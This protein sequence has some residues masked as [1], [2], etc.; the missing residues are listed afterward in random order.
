MFDGSAGWDLVT[1]L[2][3]GRVLEAQG[4]LWY[5]EPMREFDLVSYAKLCEDLKI[6]V[7]AA[8][9]SDGCHWNAAT[10]IEMKALD[11]MRT[12]THYKGGL[13]GGVKVAHLAESFGMRAEVHGGGYGNAHL[14]AAIPNNSYYEQ[15]V[16]DAEQIQGLK[17]AA[18]L[19][20]VDGFLTV[21]DTPGLGFEP[22]IERL[23]KTAIAIV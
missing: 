20:I 13:T 6:P 22:D 1:S 21:P 18:H 12:S 7:L 11:M 19:P 8:E 10:W 9:T 3:F 14:C 4:F 2:E 5:E 15:L 23:E 16:M 17:S